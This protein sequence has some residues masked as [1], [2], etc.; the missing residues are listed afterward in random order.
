MLK[1][2]TSSYR[3]GHAEGVAVRAEPER[4]AESR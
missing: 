4:E 2:T 3:G 1:T